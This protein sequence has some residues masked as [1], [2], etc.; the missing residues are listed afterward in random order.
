MPNDIKHMEFAHFNFYPV[1][2][3]AF[4]EDNNHVLSWEHRHR[5]EDTEQGSHSVGS[6]AD[7]RSLIQQRRDPL[8]ALLP[9]ELCP[10]DNKTT[11]P[12]FPPQ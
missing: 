3:T 2:K 6:V 1:S 12:G 5:R 9:V 4:T 10:S 7:Q 11:F 8:P